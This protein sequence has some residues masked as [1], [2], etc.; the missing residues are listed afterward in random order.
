MKRCIGWSCVVA[1]LTAS[2]VNLLAR[3]PAPACP[4]DL[5]ATSISINPAADRN[6]K[7]VE[8]TTI[9]TNRGLAP[10]G[11]SDTRIR[12]LTPN[13]RQ[14]WGSHDLGLIGVGEGVTF[15]SD[16]QVRGLP[17]G[18][19]EVEMECGI[20]VYEV[21]KAN[22]R[23]T[24]KFTVT[25]DPPGDDGG[26]G[27]NSDLK[28]HSVS[29]PTN[30]TAGS[31]IMITD[32]TTNLQNSACSSKSALWL[33]PTAILNTNTATSWGTH[34]VPLLANGGRYSYNSNKQ[35]PAGTS[36]TNYIIVVA[37]WGNTGCEAAGKKGN[38]T[39]TWQIIIQ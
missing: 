19:Y 18:D 21:N 8:I 3:D 35:I 1:V 38:N 2:L 28:V 16:L 30:A 15:V 25:N 20:G 9:V 14:L 10:A 23:A 29:A 26:V 32:V 36:G 33:S 37:G 12:V 34:D 24:C 17:P 31:F 39:N 5:E 4:S 13:G 11:S 7:T 27:V 22:N 6:G